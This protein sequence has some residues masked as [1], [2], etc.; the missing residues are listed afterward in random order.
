MS[1][2]PKEGP[3][4]CHTAG[5]LWSHKEHVEL[6]VEER[7][8]DSGQIQHCVSTKIFRKPLE[9]EESIPVARPVCSGTELWS[10]SSRADCTFNAVCSCWND[11]RAP[12]TEAVQYFHAILIS[13][14]ICCKINLRLVW[15]HVT[16]RVIIIYNVV[17]TQMK[18]FPSLTERES[19]DVTEGKEQ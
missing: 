1:Y 3:Q 10:H 7:E 16:R 5:S 12:L 13:S 4:L 9:A 15:A 8:G 6:L 17:G 19:W 18:L 11:F 14:S 2:L